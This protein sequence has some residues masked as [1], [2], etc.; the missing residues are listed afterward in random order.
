MKPLSEVP[1]GTWVLRNFRSADQELVQVRS[2]F[3]HNRVWFE[4]FDGVLDWTFTDEE[5]EVDD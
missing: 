2:S 4:T 3:R 5:V 1:E